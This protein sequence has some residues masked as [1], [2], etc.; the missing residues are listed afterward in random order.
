MKNIS[1]WFKKLINVYPEPSNATTTKEKSIHRRDFIS[2]AVVGGAGLVAGS[3]SATTSMTQNGFNFGDGTEQITAMP[4]PVGEAGK[5]LKSD[6]TKAEWITQDANSTSINN[7]SNV[8]PPDRQYDPTYDYMS[9]RNDANTQNTYIHNMNRAKENGVIYEANSGVDN[10]TSYHTNPWH[11]HFMYKL[12][13]TRDTVDSGMGIVVP[14]NTDIIAIRSLAD[15]RWQIFSLAK[16]D[17]TFVCSVNCSKDN[18]IYKSSGRGH[19]QGVGAFGEMNKE[20]YHKTVIFNI[21]RSTQQ[22]NYILIR[23]H[24]S[25]NDYQDGWVSGIAFNKNPNLYASNCAVDYHWQSNGGDAIVWHDG[26]WNESNLAY[27]AQQT[28]KILKV[29]IAP[30]NPDS[31]SSTRVLYAIGHGR[32]HN[33]HLMYVVINGHKYQFQNDNS[34]LAHDILCNAGRPDEFMLVSFG[35][36]DGDIPDNILS[37]GG[38]ID[39]TFNNQEYDQRYYLTEVGTY[40]KGT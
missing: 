12:S 11:Y 33:Q 23:G 39:V 21:P 26:N 17:G 27:V 22:E 8:F 18:R 13:W 6:G 20:H 19:T 10:W 16:P 34:D 5:V 35:I 30:N 28:S 37:Q 40:I 32:A 25:R 29:P 2:K 24:H 4:D 3:A 7:N 36:K 15:K 38:V 14:P 1:K 31:S 9:S